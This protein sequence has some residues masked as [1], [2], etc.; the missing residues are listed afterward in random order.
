MVVEGHSRYKKLLKPINAHAIAS[1][2]ES[3][4][5]SRRQELGKAEN[6]LKAMRAGVAL[7]SAC[8]TTKTMKHVPDRDAISALH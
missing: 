4:T 5:A 2:W 7:Y 1:K 8:L 6:E 3:M